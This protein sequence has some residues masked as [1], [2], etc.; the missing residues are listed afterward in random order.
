MSGSVLGDPLPPSRDVTTIAVDRS[1]GFWVDRVVESISSSGLAVVE[2]VLEPELVEEC[3][4]AMYRVRERIRSDVG[5]DRLDAAGEVGVL[6]LM[7][8]Y[9]DFFFR[10]SG[11]KR[12]CPGASPDRQP[13][14]PG[15]GGRAA[16]SAGG[17]G[18]GPSHRFAL[19]PTAAPLRPARCSP[20]DTVVGQVT[21]NLCFS[22]RD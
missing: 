21:F 15:R 18:E 14:P 17:A 19:V 10:P 3:R 16:P 6:R 4:A 8:Q 1:D 22:L 5:V 13:V 11:R 9:D 20:Y 7:L 2:Q 12:Q